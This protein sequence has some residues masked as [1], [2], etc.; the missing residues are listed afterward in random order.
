MQASKTEARRLGDHPLW[1]YS[2]L[3]RVWEGCDMGF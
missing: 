1:L 2:D 3:N